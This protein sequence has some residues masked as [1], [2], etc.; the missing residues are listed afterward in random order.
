MTKK[1]RTILAL[2]TTALLVVIIAFVGV[3]AVLIRDA[4]EHEPELTAYA[5][6][7]AV[8]VPPYGY[9]TPL[10]QDCHILPERGADADNSSIFSRLPCGE[11]TPDCLSGK[12]V[13]LE[14]PPGYPLQLS[15]PKKIADAPW[16]ARLVYMLPN[17]E[18]V[19]QIVSRNDYPEGSLALTIDSKPE[20]DLRLVGVE[21]Q[22]P[23]LAK[24]ETGQEFYLPHAAWSI[25]TL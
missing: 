15:L 7:T 24:D 18:T 23:I 21:M 6:G 12:T 1:T 2:G 10:M 22:L 11:E 25:S 13:R 5:H 4:P 16:I 9:C 19:D 14:V 17:G 20:P 8:T 3:L